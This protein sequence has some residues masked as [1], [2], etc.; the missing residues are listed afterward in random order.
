MAQLSLGAVTTF[1]VVFAGRTEHTRMIFHTPAANAS[2]VAVFGAITLSGQGSTAARGSGS[3]H[4][5]R[6]RTTHRGSQRTTSCGAALNHA[7]AAL[8][9]L[10]INTCNIAGA[11]LTPD[12]YGRCHIACGATVQSNDGAT[13]AHRRS[14]HPHG[15]ASGSSG[16]PGSRGGSP[17]S[18]SEARRP[19]PPLARAAS[20]SGNAARPSDAACART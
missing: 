8:W 20:R 16:I 13:H 2:S 3:A 6:A 15:R 11:I 4:G 10:A 5:N 18:A 12:V 9:D 14:A 1:L 17:R 19:G 7:D